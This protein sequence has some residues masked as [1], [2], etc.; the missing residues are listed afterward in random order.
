M[1]KAK[2]PQVIEQVAELPPEA[3]L[4]LVRTLVAQAAPEHEG[5]AE[6]AVALLAEVTVRNVARPE[7][8]FPLVS[9]HLEAL[10]STSGLPFALL[11]ATVHALLRLGRALLGVAELRISLL[12]ILAVLTKFRFLPDHPSHRKLRLQIAR[13]LRLL[14]LPHLELLGQ[15]SASVWRHV[16][17]LLRW[18]ARSPLTAPEALLVLHALILAHPDPAPASLDVG[19]QS[20]TWLRPDALPLV[21]EL[22]GKLAG[23]S[24]PAL[25][26]KAL[27]LLHQLVYATPLLLAAH[28]SEPEAQ[29]SLWQAV[30]QALAA[31]A[32]TS[33][34]S[35]QALAHLQRGLLAP[36]L[37]ALSP[38]LWGRLF[39]HVLFP[40]LDAL[41][42]RTAQGEHEDERLR[43]CALLCKTL[44][45]Y[46]SKWVGRASTFRPLWFA[47][48]A[49]LDAF[50]SPALP[51]S[52]LLAESITQATRNLLLVVH[53]AELLDEASWAQTWQRLEGFAPRLLQDKDLL[54]QLPPRPPA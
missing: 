37:F 26:G 21:L 42:T 11:S 34:L 6:F 7:L 45:Q 46:V 17:D 25:G 38:E 53:S 43:A 3:L 49:R 41:H 33:P 35:A 22:L 40:M 9:A 12:Q 50:A 47:V 31:Q 32:A 23:K 54:A 15:G 51:P 24:D 48:L 8:V 29:E 4:A 16:G 28:P 30:L 19:P 2:F 13:G 14:L 36:P 5:A 10:C 27:A 1:L 20:A 18:V 52:E 44:V 39:E